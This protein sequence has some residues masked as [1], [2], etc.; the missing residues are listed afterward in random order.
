MIKFCLEQWEKNKGALREAIEKEFTT[1]DDYE[2]LMR[3]IVKH[4]FNDAGEDDVYDAE[5]VTVVDNGN[6]QGTLL[7]VIP[8]SSYQPSEYEYLLSYIGYGSCSGC[9]ALLRAQSNYSDDDYKKF[10]NVDDVMSIALNIVQNT[11]KPYNTGWRGGEP[12]FETVE[13]ANDEVDA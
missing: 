6:Y 10:N 3:L 11:I 12:Q 9:D 5:N 4:V 7:F 13:W 8:Q 1:N 2:K